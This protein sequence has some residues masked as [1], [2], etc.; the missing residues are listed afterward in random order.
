MPVKVRKTIQKEQ[1]IPDLAQKIKQA[2]E[3]SDLSV[4]GLAKAAGISRKYWYQI[5]NDKIEGSLSYDT[6]CKIQSALGVE[7]NVKFEE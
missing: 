1:D 6:L 5:E 7:F 3:K 2:R 4:T